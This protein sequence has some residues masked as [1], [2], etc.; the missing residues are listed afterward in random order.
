MNPTKAEFS[1]SS[2]TTVDIDDHDNVKITDAPDN[3]CVILEGIHQVESL[4]AALYECERIMDSREY[5]RAQEAK[6]GQNEEGNNRTRTRTYPINSFSNC[7]IYLSGGYMSDFTEGSWVVRKFDGE[8]WPD[9]R[10][11]VGTT[12]GFC[13]MVSPRYAEH[14]ITPDH[15]LFA[16]SKD[17]YKALEAISEIVENSDHWRMDEPERGG[18]DKDALDEPLKKARG[19]T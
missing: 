8:E 9:K 19:E 15:H 17:M 7:S 11:S 4:R 18:I 13:L 10:I 6:K 3:E 12:E 1:V 16:A 14:E 2:S 5:D